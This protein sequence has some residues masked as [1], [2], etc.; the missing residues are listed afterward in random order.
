[1]QILPQRW[2]SAEGPDEPYLNYITSWETISEVILYLHWKL[3]AVWLS[4]CFCVRVQGKL[5]I[6]E[7]YRFYD[8]LRVSNLDL[9]S[10]VR[11]QFSLT[12][13]WSCVT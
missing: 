3:V 7:A 1:M 8:A 10:R 6:H 2:S 13:H 9:I 5:I 11:F 4:K 12:D